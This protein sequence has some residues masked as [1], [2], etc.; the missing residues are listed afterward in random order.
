VAVTSSITA[1]HFHT[2]ASHGYGTTAA[3]TGGL[4]WAMWVCGLASLAAIP[5]AYALIRGTRKPDMI[6]TAQPVVLVGQEGS[7]LM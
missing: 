7:P 4:Q 2:L 5:A 3:L 6:T 1:T